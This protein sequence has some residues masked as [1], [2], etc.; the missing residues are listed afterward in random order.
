[1]KRFPNIWSY[2]LNEVSADLSLR[3]EHDEKLGAILQIQGK[4]SKDKWTKWFRSF[5]HTSVFCSLKL[6]LVPRK[7]EQKPAALQKHWV[8]SRLISEG[9]YNEFNP[10][11]LQSTFCILVRENGAR[12]DSSLKSENFCVMFIFRFYHI[13]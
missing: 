3:A 4:R 13:L 9:P 12:I 2:P 1:M 6:L 8:W 10:K 5:F 7:S 11:R